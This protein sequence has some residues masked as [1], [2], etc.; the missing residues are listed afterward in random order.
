MRTSARALEAQ[1]IRV[2]YLES[3]DLRTRGAWASFFKQYK[4]H[5]LVCYDVVDTWLAQ[6][7]RRA[8][9]HLGAEL[10]FL[11]T[12]QFLN[13]SEENAALLPLKKKPFMKTF[14]EAQRKRLGVLMHADGTP[15]GGK[16]SFDTEN[17]KRLPKNHRIPSPLSLPSSPDVKEAIAYTNAHFA[18]HYGEIDTFSYATDHH[19]AR[20][21]LHHFLTHHLADFGAYEDA[22]SS[23]QTVLH[24]ST[25]SPYLNS[26]LLT[27]HEVLQATLAHAKTHTI[28][29][30]SLEGFLRQL[31]GW[32]EFI[33]AMYTL[34][35]NRMRT[36][37]ALH[38]TKHL[39]SGFW[40]A[41]TGN[42]VLDTS[43]ARV[44]QHAYCHH[45]ERLMVLGNY[46][47]L[48]ETHPDEVYAWFMTMFID[49][50]DWVMVP[51]VYGMSQFADGG[52]FATKPYIAAANYILR[53][54]DYRRDGVWDKAFDDAFWA[55]LK[56]HRTLLAKNPRF[57]MLLT[58]LH[59]H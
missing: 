13:S 21:V 14:Y 12:P 43:I 53:M 29:L 3:H 2:T 6:D 35:G 4:P 44:A 41:T 59:K 28:P 8:A 50:Y 47:L 57:R 54:S 31:I 27:P 58:Q 15:V 22:I 26:G 39:P 45:I 20:K 17:R 16:F 56:K 11:P 52:I 46:L 34:H 7:I 9:K 18:Q 24:H 48:H 19:G 1:G 51:N 38:A 25:L 49:A 5:T 42:I 40:D 32:R 10:T 37:N 23:T 55:F 36:S 33:R 30:N